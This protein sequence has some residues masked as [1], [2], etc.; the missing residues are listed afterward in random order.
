MKVEIVAEKLTVQGTLE[1]FIMLKTPPGK[2]W[3]YMETDPE[4]W[5]VRLLIRMDKAHRVQWD[6]EKERLQ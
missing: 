1:A 2:I 3:A 5:D 4:W 6:W